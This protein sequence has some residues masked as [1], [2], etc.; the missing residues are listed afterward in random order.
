MGNGGAVIE[1]SWSFLRAI[2]TM[3]VEM[4]HPDMLADRK[5]NILIAPLSR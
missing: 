3:A 1:S 4:S 2:H 5:T